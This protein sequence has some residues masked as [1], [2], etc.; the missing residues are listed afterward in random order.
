MLVV[1]TVSPE[2]AKPLGKG[3]DHVEIFLSEY[4]RQDRTEDSATPDLGLSLGHIQRI[5]GIDSLL[6]GVNNNPLCLIEGC[7]SPTNGKALFEFLNRYGKK[8]PIIHA[9]DLIDVKTIFEQQGILMPN[10]DFFVMDATRLKYNNESIG[11]VAQDFLLNCAPHNTHYQIMHEAHRVMQEGGVGLICYTDHQCVLGKERITEKMLK[12][13]FGVSLNGDAFSVV[14]LLSQN[15]SKDNGLYNALLTGLQD[16]VLINGSED[17]WTYV[18]PHGGNFEFFRPPE[19]YENLFKKAGLKTVG[20]EE[21][22][23]V[24]R[25]GITCV[26]YRTVLHKGD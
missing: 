4:I 8:N 25:N 20:M 7:T 10:L 11:V 12:K 13:E 18:T 16:K 24:D 2:I 19:S 21:S 17:R 26:R 22:K 3:F 14:D 6:A 5:S 9:I 23:G 1:F 15:K